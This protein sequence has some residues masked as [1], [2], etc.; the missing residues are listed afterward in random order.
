MDCKDAALQRNGD[1]VVIVCR[2]AR[3]SS[4]SPLSSQVSVDGLANL[5]VTVLS[6]SLTID[7]IDVDTLFSMYGPNVAMCVFYD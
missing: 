2:S 1:N 5:N 3:A 7:P 4:Q 6:S